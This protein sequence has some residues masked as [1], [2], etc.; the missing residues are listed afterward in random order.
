[1]NSLLPSDAQVLHSP[2]LDRPRP[3][4]Q[5][6]G[7]LL[8]RHLTTLEKHQAALANPALAGQSC[9]AACKIG[10]LHM[11]DRRERL[12]QGEVGGPGRTQVL[13]FRCSRRATCGA[14]WRI[15]P[16]FLAR[17]LWRRWTLVGVV[18]GGSRHRVPQRTEQ[19]WRQRLATAAAV[20][21]ALLEQA[22]THEW[23]DVA[24]RAGGD[25]TRSDVIA[26]AG[27]PERLAN[28]AAI[29]DHLEAGVRLM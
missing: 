15:L 27:G 6:G 18:L 21:V 2:Y 22:P 14:T 19:R 23:T 5:K 12:F 26:A 16:H 1:M 17:H 13:I 4:K 3:R 29:I 28:L 20:M 8:A 24:V 11:H 9:C 7:T 10:G 25:A